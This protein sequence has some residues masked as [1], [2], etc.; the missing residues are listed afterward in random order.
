MRSTLL[1]I[2][3]EYKVLAH[4]TI[5]RDSKENKSGFLIFMLGIMTS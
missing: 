3:F 4:S 1:L 2:K 5:D